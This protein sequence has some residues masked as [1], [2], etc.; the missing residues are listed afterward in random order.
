VELPEVVEES[1]QACDDDLGHD[2]EQGSL[3]ARVDRCLGVGAN[4]IGKVTV[5][6][7]DDLDR[8]SDPAVLPG[9]PHRFCAFRIGCEMQCGDVLEAE[10]LGV[11]RGAERRGV[12]DIEIATPD[13]WRKRS[14]SLNVYLRSVRHGEAVAN[15]SGIKRAGGGLAGLSTPL[16]RPT[17]DP[18]SSP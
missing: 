14:L 6:A 7:G 12:Y 10:R 18:W 11:G 2:I 1:T 15:C 17:R 8:Q 16:L 9:C 5:R 13:S 4:K 3:R